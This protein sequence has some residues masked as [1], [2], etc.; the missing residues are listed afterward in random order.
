[1]ENKLTARQKVTIF[2]MIFESIIFFTAIMAFIYTYL[3]NKYPF[4]FYY[5]DLGGFYIAGIVL[6][7]VSV[8]LC[9]AI[10]MT[11]GYKKMCKSGTE[12]SL[13][14]K[15]CTTLFLSRVAGLIMFLEG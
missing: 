11:I 14:F 13:L 1:M 15:I 4:L 8:Y 5:A 6:A 3:D 7:V 2:F 10:P 9:I 12:V